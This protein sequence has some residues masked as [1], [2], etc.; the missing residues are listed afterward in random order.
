[1][2]ASFFVIVLIAVLVMACTP[3]ATVPDAATPTSVLNPDD[4]DAYYNRGVGYMDIGQYERAIEDY[5]KAIQLNPD[6]VEAYNIRAYSYA[7]L[8]QYLRV[9]DDHNKACSLDQQWC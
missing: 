4:A 2:K 8:G 3:K 7:A 5:T 1:M 9:I 6:D